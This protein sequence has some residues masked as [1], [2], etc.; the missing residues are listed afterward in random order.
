MS[1]GL[2]VVWN[3]PSVISLSVAATWTPRPT[4]S[5]LEPPL[6]AVTPEAPRSTCE[7][8]SENE[9]WADLKPTV[10]TFAR[11]LA[12]LLSIV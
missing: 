3:E 11:S 6:L 4:C 8:E 12:V 1:S 7:S 9:M 5:G 10:F 2:F